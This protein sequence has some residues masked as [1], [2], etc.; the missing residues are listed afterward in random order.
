MPK[1]YTKTKT[2]MI[3]GTKIP[4]DD[5]LKRQMMEFIH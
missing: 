4:L 1:N 3:F 5:S 2:K